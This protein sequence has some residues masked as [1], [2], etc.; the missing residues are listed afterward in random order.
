MDEQ[1][2]TLHDRLATVWVWLRSA[3]VFAV[4][5]IIPTTD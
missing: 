1:A 3:P 2:V 4:E 5:I